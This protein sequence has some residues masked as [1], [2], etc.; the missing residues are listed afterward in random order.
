[1][2]C[3]Q[4][5]DSLRQFVESQPHF[6]PIYFVHPSPLELGD[7][8]FA[9]NFPGAGHISDPELKLYDLF[10]IRRL[11]PLRL[12]NPKGILQ[13]FR[14]MLRGYRNSDFGR[15]GNLWVL[16]GTFL[17]LNGK[18]VWQHR[19]QFAGDDPQ[20]SRLSALAPAKPSKAERQADAAPA[21]DMVGA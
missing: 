4:S 21:P 1:M 20:W 15:S 13:G 12:L 14:N 3:K 6:P 18:L 7:R 2:Y 17:F 5:V 16:S 8:F 19:A 11:S 9:E 10:G